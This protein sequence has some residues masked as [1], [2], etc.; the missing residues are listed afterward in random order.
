MGTLACTFTVARGTHTEVDVV[1]CACLSQIHIYTHKFPP[2]PIQAPMHVHINYTHI[3]RDHAN[4]NDCAIIH[5]RS[6]KE[7]PQ[8]AGDCSP[9]TVAGDSYADNDVWSLCYP[10][11]QG[12][13]ET[14]SP[15]I[16]GYR[17]QV[18]E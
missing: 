17:G 10:Q 5:T 1:T 14:V 8:H 6:I 9:H 7:N 11:A 2:P 15:I 4:T 12:W 18:K 3:S 13:L 16:R